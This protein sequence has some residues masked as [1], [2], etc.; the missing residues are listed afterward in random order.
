MGKASRNKGA[1]GERELAFLLSQW[2]GMSIQ[3]KLGAAREGGSDIEWDGWSIEVKRAERLAIVK[4]WKQCVDQ[5]FK[6]GNKP[7][8]CWKQ[9]RTLWF[10]MF[11]NDGKEVLV[12]LSGWYDMHYTR[13]AKDRRS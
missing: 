1:R 13:Y 5:A 7:L 10:C 3:R 2:T 4:W 6:E 8:L 9:N 11:L 12:P